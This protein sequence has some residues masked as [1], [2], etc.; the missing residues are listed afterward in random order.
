MKQGCFIPGLNI[1]ILDPKEI[2]KQKPDYVVILPWNLKHEIK[3]ELDFIK[4]WGGKFIS[5]D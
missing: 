5:F 2:K 1:K 3:N 4:S